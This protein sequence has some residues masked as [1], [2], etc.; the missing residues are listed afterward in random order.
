MSSKNHEELAD[1]SSLGGFALGF[2]LVLTGK[3]GQIKFLSREEEWNS[4]YPNYNWPNMV[5]GSC[6]SFGL[7]AS[8]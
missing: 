8:N 4:N 2:F 1:N 5:Q 3:K 6:I 7:S